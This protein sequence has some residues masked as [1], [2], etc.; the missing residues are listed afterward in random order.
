MAIP[1]NRLVKVNDLFEKITGRRPIDEDIYQF[2]EENGDAVERQLT[3]EVTLEAAKPL[4]AHHDLFRVL[5][6]GGGSP[7]FLY[8]RQVH[9]E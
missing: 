3:P 7:R 9:Y 2:V 8:C 6:A 5:R 1:L 4:L